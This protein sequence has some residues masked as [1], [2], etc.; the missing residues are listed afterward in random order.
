[1]KLQGV[2]EE[3]TGILGKR[4]FRRLLP[5]DGQEILERYCAKIARDKLQTA[6]LRSATPKGFHEFNE[7]EDPDSVDNLRALLRMMECARQ[8]NGATK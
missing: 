6:T 8:Q 2:L 4:G 7:L 1:M 3:A 5:L